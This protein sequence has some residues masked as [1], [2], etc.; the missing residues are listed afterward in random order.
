[1]KTLLSCSLLFLSIVVFAQKRVRPVDPIDQKVKALLAKMTLEEKVGQLNQYSG[2]RDVTGPAGDKT[3]NKLEDIKQGKVGAMLNIRGVKEIRAVQEVAMQ[4]RLKIPLI[5][6]LDVIH[7]F[8]VTFPVPLGETASWDLNAIELSARYTGTQA[9]AAGVN[10]TFAPMV[11]IA[12]D[13]R[14]GRVMEGAGEDTYLGSLVAKA[15]VRGLQGK[16]LG[17]LDAIMACA[18][19][20]AAYGAGLAGRE[21]AAADISDQTLLNVYLPP[22][23][24]AVDAGVATL[25]N[26]FNTVNGVPATGNSYLQRDILKG[27]WQFKGFVVS[28]FG[29]IGELVAHGYAENQEDA[30]RLAITAGSDMDMESRSYILNLT[31]L[32]KERKIPVSVIDDAAGRI[33]RKKFELGLFDDPYRFC[34][35]EREKQVLGD[36]NESLEAARKVGA[37]SIVLLKNENQVLPLS[38]KLKSIAVIGPLAKSNDLK[39]GWSQGWKNDQ[40]VSL[41]EGLEAKVGNGTKLLYAR[42]C[43]FNDTLRTGFAEAVETAKNADVIIAAIGESSGMTGEATSRTDISIPG[44]Q[45]DLIK[46]LVATGKPLVVLIMSGRPL[47]FN[48]TADHANSILYT[49]W[50]GSQSG[51]SMADVLFGDYNPS[52]KL[53]I[54]FPRVLG[55]IPIYYN[56]L[57]TGRPLLNPKD[58]AWKSVY[59]DQP[60]TPKFAFGYGL[61]YTTFEY[62]N[63]KLDKTKMKG[64]EKLTVTMDLTNTGKYA[65][66]E[67]VQ[68]YL[69]DKFASIARPVKEL[70]DFQ[71]VML[72]PGETKK[73][74]FVIDKQKLSFFNQK[75][76]WVAEPG[77][78]KLMIGTASDN[79]KLKSNFELIN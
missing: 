22:F 52:G 46:A 29:S 3:T 64:T 23:K 15:R 74:S 66:E 49:W 67:V 72:K 76:K 43:N 57:S 59:M 27:Q 14:W 47:T 55:Q 65:G 34:N 48:Y 39:G 69:Q 28:D 20:F 51:N 61:S 41:Y 70:K 36:L 58:R 78:F 24:A 12:R 37:K 13:P 4:S 5:F 1:M 33:L 50:L 32:V 75:L 53:P 44:V 54:T 9:A 11:D 16:G 63:L 77:E 10:W 62:Q 56:E 71:K 60:N 25:M 17:N 31:R 42:G 40:I 30:A 26:S 73:L 19:H 21:Y 68:L 6:G 35:E 2:T 38:K 7:G 18:K 45:E 8:R 79:I